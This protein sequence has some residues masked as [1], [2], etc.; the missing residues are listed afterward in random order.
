MQ[1]ILEHKH[2][3]MCSLPNGWCVL[4]ISDLCKAVLDCNHSTPVWTA[5]GSVVI[6]NQ[7]IKNGKL[8]LSDPSFTDDEHYIERTRRAVPS[9][10][11][12]VVTREAP[13]GL[14]C[15]IPKDLQCCLGQRM[16]LLRPNN[17]VVDSGYLLYAL[18]SES[19]QRN[20]EVAAGTGSTVSN[21]R[22]PV[23]KDL[24]IPTPPLHE[25]KA[26]AA[27]LR[28][29]D[30]QLSLLDRIVEKKRFLKQAAMQQLLTG[31]SRLPGFSGDWVVKRLEQ[32]A[33]ICTGINKPLSE[34]GSGSLYVTVQ[35]LY[36][37]TSIRTDRLSRIKV[38]P[39]EIETR[40]LVIG[41]IVFG[42]SSVKRDGIGYPSQ[43]LGCNEPVVFSGF[44]YRARARKG[45]ADATFLFYALREE[46]TRRWLIDNSQASALTNINQTIADSIPI[47]VPPSVLEQKSIASVL[48]EM[49]LDL[50][51]LERQEEK[52]RAFKQSIMQELLTGKTR[53]IAKEVTH[54]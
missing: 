1:N 34:M 45:I 40:G 27:V 9:W 33:E 37:K 46:K 5:S 16:V 20:M 43:F 4:R 52:T 50:A 2:S 48:A 47:K 10:G 28:D 32:V 54:V 35:D 26:I 38:T 25:Q 29:V 7:N 15:M 8:D 24:R 3:E 41:D 49:D 13:V 21:L 19:I 18:L 51:V 17:D 39:S 42:K 36:D 11:D 30:E 23:L 6:R 22:I 53:L 44:T 14:V 12:L 31:K